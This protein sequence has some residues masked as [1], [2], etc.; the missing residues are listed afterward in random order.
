[1]EA[2][3]H[4][5]L[6]SLAE[7]VGINLTA[8]Y[9]MAQAAAAIWDERIPLVH[10]DNWESVVVDEA[11]SEEGEKERVWFLVMYVYFLSSL[12]YLLSFSSWLLTMVVLKLVARAQQARTNKAASRK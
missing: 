9:A 10:D 8:T 7:K 11:L 12:L 6:N 3:I 4:G 5:P 2:L 1:M